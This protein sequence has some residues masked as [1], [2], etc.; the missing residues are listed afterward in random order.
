[1][2]NGGA[3]FDTKVVPPVVTALLC[4]KVFLALHFFLGLPQRGERKRRERERERERVGAKEEEE[5][6][7]EGETERRRREE[8]EEGEG[9]EGGG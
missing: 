7:G 6:I 9:K 4:H 1:M 5:R 8:G 3:I 2:T